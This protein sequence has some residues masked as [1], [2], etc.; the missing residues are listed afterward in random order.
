MCVSKCH[1]YMSENRSGLSKSYHKL[2]LLSHFHAKF[3]LPFSLSYHLPS[4]VSMRADLYRCRHPSTLSKQAHS[5][6]H[7]SFTQLP[8]HLSA[9]S[10][11]TG[12]NYTASVVCDRK[13]MCWRE[14]QESRNKKQ[15]MHVYLCGSAGVCLCIKQGECLLYF[16]YEIDN[17]DLDR[18]WDCGGDGEG[19]L[20]EPCEGDE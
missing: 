3:V 16:I 17:L 6:L 11:C 5:P 10:L 9:P 1:L 13:N 18:E 2:D 4:V 7:V 20:T 14:S 12:S 15:N 19:G 8:A